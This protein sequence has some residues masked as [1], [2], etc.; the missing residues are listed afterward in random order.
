LKAREDLATLLQSEN[1]TKEKIKEL[2]KI[3]QSKERAAYKTL[4]EMFVE[5][6]RGRVDDLRDS[7]QPMERLH[8]L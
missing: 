8:S 3:I 7:P 5:S 1:P 6:L 2:Q 4:P